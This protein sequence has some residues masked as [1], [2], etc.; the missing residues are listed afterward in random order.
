MLL[1]G[2]TGGYI[3][4]EANEGGRLPCGPCGRQ[5]GA[6]RLGATPQTIEHLGH[7]FG[8]LGDVMMVN[9]SVN[10]AGQ[11]RLQYGS[12]RENGCLQQLVNLKKCDRVFKVPNVDTAKFGESLDGASAQEERMMKNSTQRNR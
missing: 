8:S 6:S 9:I 7:F 3:Q 2:P 4:G 11:H 10:R 1:S 12:F 5:V